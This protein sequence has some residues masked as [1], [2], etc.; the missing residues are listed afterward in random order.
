QCTVG[1]GPLARS[2]QTA[3]R[4]RPPAKCER[5]ANIP[6]LVR[7]VARQA[8]RAIGKWFPIQIGRRACRGARRLIS[9]TRQA[10]EKEQVMSFEEMAGSAK[11]PS[12]PTEFK[13]DESPVRAVMKDGEP[14]FIAKD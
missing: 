4:R 11:S 8:R 12:L 13:F 14:W 6:V 5:S 10:A 1:A 2:A 9:M 3:R 7:A